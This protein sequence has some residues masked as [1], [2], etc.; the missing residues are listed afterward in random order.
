[1][2]QQRSWH[3]YRNEVSVLH[4]KENWKLEGKSWSFRVQ[5]IV[6]DFL[7]HGISSLLQEDME[8]FLTLKP[9]SEVTV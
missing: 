1:M 2:E 9:A 4:K 6:P 5:E 8:Y 7:K 3:T